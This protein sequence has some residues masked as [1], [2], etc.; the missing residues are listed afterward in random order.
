[1]A[2]SAERVENLVLNRVSLWAWGPVLLVLGAA[3]SAFRSNVVVLVA[4]ATLCSFLVGAWVAS[5]RPNADT[6]TRPHATSSSPQPTQS[7]PAGKR[8]NLSGALLAGANLA[9]ADLRYADLRGADL[10]NADLRGANLANAALTPLEE[11]PPA[12]GRDRS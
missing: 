1:M 4:I 6:P 8:T 2:A 3:V 9:N 10:T 11:D 12:D 7:A 5:L